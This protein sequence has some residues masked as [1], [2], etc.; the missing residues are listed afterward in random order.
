ML[1]TSCRSCRFCPAS[2]S[3]SA[4][5]A[6][7]CFSLQEGESAQS[8]GQVRAIQGKPAHYPIAHTLAHAHRGRRSRAQQHAPGADLHAALKLHP[9]PWMLV[10]AVQHHPKHGKQSI[11]RALRD[12]GRRARGR[13]RRAAIMHDGATAAAAD[14][15][16]CNA[17]LRRRPAPLCQAPPTSAA[18]HAPPHPCR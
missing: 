14:F 7:T 10:D 8:C 1:C 16:C 5:M 18:A 17:V 9:K 2:S 13:A 11:R 12:V 4:R 15:G 6:D 3:S